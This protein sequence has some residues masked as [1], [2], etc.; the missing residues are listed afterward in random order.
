M[1]PCAP[2]P[3]DPLRLRPLARHETRPARVCLVR[4]ILVTSVAVSHL[5]ARVSHADSNPVRLTWLPSGRESR[6]EELLLHP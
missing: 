3:D 6:G 2:Q 1:A 5:D 4:G